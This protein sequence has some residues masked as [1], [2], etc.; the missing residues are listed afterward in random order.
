MWAGQGKLFSVSGRPSQGLGEFRLVDQQ[1]CV[2]KSVTRVS[3]AA[4]CAFQLSPS[5]ILQSAIH[6]LVI[7]QRLSRLPAGCV[8]VLECASVSG[9]H[10][11]VNVLEQVAELDRTRVLD[12]LDEAQQ[13]GLI[14]VTSS[15][16]GRYQ[17]SHALVQ[18][19]VYTSLSLSRRASLHRRMGAA[20]ERL[21]PAEIDNYL[22]E[23]A[24]H[25]ARAAV[26][27]DIAPAVEY[28]LRAGDRALEQIAYSEAIDHY[29]RAL[30]IVEQST[31]V[32]YTDLLEVLLR[33]G[34][35]QNH[36][37]LRDDARK[38]FSRAAD[39]SREL[40]L[41]TQLAQAAL[42]YTGLGV[43]VGPPD[44]IPLL[45]EAVAWLPAEDTVLR[46][47]VVA[48]L[49][50]ETWG[51][52]TRE[53][54]KWLLQEAEGVARR[55]GDPST[56]SFVLIKACLGFD[57][58]DNLEARVA[59]TSEALDLV[60]KSGEVLL[61]PT[62]HAMGVYNGLET[63]DM[64]LLDQEI[65]SF[66]VLVKRQ[67]QPQRQW[68][69]LMF[70]AVR[71]VTRGHF[72]EAEQHIDRAREVSSSI[73]T[74]EHY[75]AR[76]LNMVIAIDRERGR[77]TREIEEKL[78]VRI[79]NDMDNLYWRALL[80]W[81]RSESKCG[82]G[83]ESEIEDLI[84]VIRRVSTLDADSLAAAAL[85]S[86]TEHVTTHR[87]LARALYDIIS[88]FRKHNVVTRDHGRHWYGPATFFT[89]CL[90]ATLGCPDTA[91]RDL[92][93]ALEVNQRMQ[94]RPCLARNQYELARVLR[95]RGEPGDHDRS[96]HLLNDALDIALDVGMPVL[97]EEINAEVCGAV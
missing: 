91:V 52:S 79:Q 39:V 72:T 59:M 56:L 41:S 15:G 1:Q 13:S 18:E 26:G 31:P 61:A 8:L 45:E 77:L 78:E 20:L 53:R 64:R 42:G 74:A 9:R 3:D 27:G 67:R 35:A 28:G 81:L 92:Q 70:K 57:T 23:L 82:A 21:H 37:G 83:V 50:F 97:V 17:F 60:Q 94:A 10:F 30:A 44:N 89:G 86:Q 7:G 75:D 71:A 29:R 48:R 87:P 93:T 36:I 12:A 96:I 25:Y 73:M 51:S 80:A 88:P 58:L 11:N 22:N 40:E 24:H 55:V 19:T 49:A 62:V 95:R 33:L 63:G 38:T 16:E 68:L 5:G 65:A 46:A 2:D 4:S 14:Q 84:E 90:S 47:R 54:R 66:D 6:H 85:L 76:V 34:D 69:A 43:F 32:A